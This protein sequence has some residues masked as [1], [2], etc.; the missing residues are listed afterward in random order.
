MMHQ[1]TS[2]AACTIGLGLAVLSLVPCSAYAGQPQESSFTIRE[3]LILGDDEDAPEEYLFYYPLY[4]RTDSHDNIYINDARRADVRVFDANGQFLTTI[5]RRGAGPGEMKEIVSMHV[6]GDD[7]LIVVDRNSRRLTIFTDMGKDFSVEN[8]I[9]KGFI[10]PNPILSL[11]GTFLLSEVRRFANPEGGPRLLDDWFLHLHDTELNRIETFGLLTDIFDLSSPF[12][13]AHSG[14]SRAFEVA[15]DGINTIVVAPYVYDGRIYRYVRSPDRWITE[16][17]KGRD[18][19]AKAFV[20]ISKEKFDSS[21]DARRGTITRSSP[22]GPQHVR[23]FSRSRGIGILST[24]QILHFT[25]RTPP[26]EDFEPLVELYGQDGNLE[27]Y[28]RLLFNNPELNGNARVMES[29]ALQW[30][31]AADRLFIARRNPDGFFVLSVAELEITP[32]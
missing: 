25:L 4:V 23:V 3:Q 29:I 16:K 11:D 24:G 31:D 9:D 17:L 21:D 2:H 5:G 28:G 20:P 7:R 14:S 32:L 18:I 1:R 27:A 8:T 30:M 10:M 12:L 22:T 13:R 15:T 19:A 26:K 6:D